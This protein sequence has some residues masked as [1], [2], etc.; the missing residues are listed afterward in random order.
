[1]VLYVEPV[2]ITGVKPVK[3]I[4]VIFYLDAQGLPVIQMNTK[5]LKP[6]FPVTQDAKPVQITQHVPVVKT[7]NFW[8]WENANLVKQNMVVIVE[9]VI[10]VNV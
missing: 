4:L 5:Y 3:I 9:L 7:M 2:I 6:V 10:R 8:K 1:M